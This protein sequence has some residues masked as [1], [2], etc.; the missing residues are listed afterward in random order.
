MTDYGLKQVRTDPTQRRVVLYVGYQ[1]GRLID[2]VSKYRSLKK[3]EMYSQIFD[4]GM[5]ALFGISLEE[6]QD[7]DVAPLPSGAAVPENLQALTDLL[8]GEPE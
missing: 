3:H 4:A 1:E 6:L 2:L 5:V 8:C 7:C